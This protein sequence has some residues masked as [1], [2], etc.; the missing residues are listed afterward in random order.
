M[1]TA[2]AM[3][4]GCA[5]LIGAANAHAESSLFDQATTLHNQAQHDRGEVEL[6]N[7]LGARRLWAGE[8]ARARIGFPPR[9]IEH[10]VPIVLEGDPQIEQPRRRRRHQP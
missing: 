6:R 10:I 3:M 2:L 5:A 4:V 9:R 1:R 8:V 7:A